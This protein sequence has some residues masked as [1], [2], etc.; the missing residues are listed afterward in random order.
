[1][2]EQLWEYCLLME[3]ALHGTAALHEPAAGPGNDDQSLNEDLRADCRVEYYGATGTVA[4]ALT[5]QDGARIFGR[6]MGLLGAAGW[7]LVTLLPGAEA[8]AAIRRPGLADLHERI[9]LTS[10]GAYFKRPT[11]PGRLVDEPKLVL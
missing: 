4:V 10:K 2:S 1:M 6:A 8:T 5:N 11:M 9:P 7:E 3:Y